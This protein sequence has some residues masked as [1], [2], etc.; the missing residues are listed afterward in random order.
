MSHKNPS[1]SQIINEAIQILTE[2]GLPL[3]SKTA[4]Q[5]ERTAMAF[6]AV[7]GVTHS[8]SWSS[9]G[10][11]PALGTRQIIKFL[12]QHFGENLA[13]GSY[14]D[15]RRQALKEAVMAGLVVASAGKPGAAINDPTRGYG[16]SEDFANLVRTFGLTD[17]A[18]RVAKFMAGRPSLKDQIQKKPSAQA[19]PLIL[20]GGKSLVLSS[21]KHNLIQKAVVEEFLPRFGQ[22]A[23]VVYLG[24]TAQKELHAD[25][26]LAKRLGLDLDLSAKIPDIIAW[27]EEKN[28]LFLIEAVHSFGPISNQ[29]RME[30]EKFAAGSG[31]GLVFVTAFLDVHA[32][33]KCTAEI[34]WDTEVWLASDPSHM[35]HWNGDR[36]L[37]PRVNNPATG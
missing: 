33:R 31:A 14:D 3:T 17:W 5:R 35:I 36:F 8:S 23:R 26:T 9:A 4:R 15:I 1:T 37:G 13:P 7:A 11:G 10:H 6:L 27:S 30:L 28:W 21:G 20:P 16:L 32:F 24:D 22:G 19:V 2:C 25:H 34:G 12:N 18:S 29:R